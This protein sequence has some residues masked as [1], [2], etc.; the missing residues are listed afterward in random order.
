VDLD[1]LYSN[2]VSE[3]RA[4]LSFANMPSRVSP[5][6]LSNIKM[7]ATIREATASF[8]YGPVFFGSF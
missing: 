8:I 5:E 2:R 4:N 6:E 1:T 7:I 3:P